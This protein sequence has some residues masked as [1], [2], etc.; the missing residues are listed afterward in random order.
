M[1]RATE[2]DSPYSLM[3][4]LIKAPL[5]SKRALARALLFLVL[6]TPVGPK[7]RK[8]QLGDSL[9]ESPAFLNAGLPLPLIWVH[10]LVTSLRLRDVR[11]GGDICRSQFGW[12]CRLAP[13]PARNHGC[14]PR[15]RPCPEETSSILSTSFGNSLQLLLFCVEGREFLVSDFSNS[16]IICVTFELFC[17]EHEFFSVLT[18]FLQILHHLFLV[19]VGSMEFFCSS[20]GWPSSFFYVDN[21]SCFLSGRSFAHGEELRLIWGVNFLVDRVYLGRFT[22][23]SN[24]ERWSSLIDEIDSFI[25]EFTIWQVSCR[26][27]YCR[28]EGWV[29]NLYSMKGFLYLS[30]IPR[31]IVRASSV[32]FIDHH[33]L[34]TSFKRCIFFDV[35]SVFINRRCTNDFDSSSCKRRLQEIASICRSFAL[36][37]APTIV[38]I[39]SIKRTISLSD[40]STSSMTD[41]SR[42]SNSPDISPRQSWPEVE[43][44]NFLTERVR[45][46]PLMI[47]IAI[48]STIAVLPTPGSPIRTGLFLLRRARDL[49]GSTDFIIT[50]DDRSIFPFSPDRWDRWC[51]FSVIH[52]RF[53]A[54]FE[55]TFCHF[56]VFDRFFVIFQWYISALKIPSS[57]F[58]DSRSPIMRVLLWCNYPHIFHG[59]FRHF[60]GLFQFLEKLMGSAVFPL[61]FANFDTALST[62]F[63]EN[64]NIAPARS[65]RDWLMLSEAC[66]ILK[67]DEVAQW[68]YVHYSEANWTDS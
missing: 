18:D 12:V 9:S 53:S 20:W 5:W 50:S 48:P 56:S 34:K 65:R 44:Q 23:R 62:S 46:S 45:T 7:N 49:D 41:L 66:K 47:R 1:R 63:F 15:C 52:R 59:F 29:S 27:V 4:I 42:S 10:G 43:G 60:G 30:L 3:S 36:A 57:D 54:V 14:Y 32:W 40:F 16:S 22:G 28:D 31:R 35:F 68:S 24:L 33:W 21:A 64:L 17:L 61:T 38:W 51:I 26:H 19:F 55:V 39:S 25:R 58:A 13:W 2:C 8:A 11:R 37:P 67:R 6:P